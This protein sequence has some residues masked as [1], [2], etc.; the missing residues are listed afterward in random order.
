MTTALELKGVKAAYGTTPV[1][2]GVG[3]VVPKGTVVA[4]LGPNG[5]GKTTALRVAAGLLRPNAGEVRLWDEPVTA[6]RE[7]DRARRGIT[8]IPEGRGIFRQL[9]V[10]ENI[11]MFAGGKGVRDAIE[12]AAS[13]FPILGERLNQDAG[14]LSGG[15]QQMLAVSRALCTDAQIILADELSLGLAPVIIDE[16]FLAIEALLAEGRSLLLVEQY[17]ERALA[18]ADDVYIL[19]KGAVVFE[20]SPDQCIAEDVFARYVGSAAV[21]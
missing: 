3:L 18:V 12:R 14:T 5:A 15:Q 2:H 10:R 16:I 11:A 7:H 21:A 8:Y 20:G 4:L 6:L 17:A 19:S 13:I 9:S 1:L